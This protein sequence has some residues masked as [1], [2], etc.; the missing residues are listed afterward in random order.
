MLYSDQV[1]LDAPQLEYFVSWG[2]RV[3][4]LTQCPMQVLARKSSVASA[5]TAA[6][7]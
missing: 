7:G 1:S 6:K 2:C 3:I 4:D 5:R